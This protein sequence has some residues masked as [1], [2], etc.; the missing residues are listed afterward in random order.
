MK[1]QK[2]LEN[3]IYFLMIIILIFPFFKGISD[4]HIAFIMDAI[5]L[6]GLIYKIIKNGFIRY[7]V[8]FK[9]IAIVAFSLSYLI[10]SIYAVDKTD[11][12][13][14]FFKFATIP[15]FLFLVMQY[16]LT[17]SEKN[18]LLNTVSYS[19]A[20][21]VILGLV[22]FAFGYTKMFHNNRFS[23]FFAY[24]NSFAMWLLMGI[25]ITACKDKLKWYDFVILNV[26][27]IGIILT[28]SRAIIILSIAVYI[29]IILFNKTIRK[30]LI[31]NAGIMVVVGAITYFILTKFGIFSRIVT[32]TSSEG[33]L[34]LLYYKDALRMIK[35]NIF[36]YG[37]F[38]WWNM[39]PSFQTGVYYARY[40]HNSFLQ[41]VFDVGII[42][43]LLIVYIFVSGFFDKKSTLTEKILMFIVLGHSLIDFDIEFMAITMILFLTLNFDKQKTVSHTKVIK[44]STG[45]FLAFYMYFGAVTFAQ[46]IGKYDI[47]NKIYPYWSNTLEAELGSIKDFDEKVVR[48]RKVMKLNKYY[49]QPYY[50][51][52]EYYQRK[53]NYKKA[54]EYEK[55]V[56]AIRKYDK[57][58]YLKYINF[59]LEAIQVSILQ[60][61]NESIKF[62]SKEIVEVKDKINNVIE[63]SDELA[64]EIEHKPD[65]ELDEEILDMIEKLKKQNDF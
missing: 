64:F 37:Y 65:L 60:K 51:I 29:A 28:N 56:L 46:N 30:D 38:A 61:D 45:V 31:K 47:A 5:L 59:L 63:E 26:L 53:N 43:A 58:M 62:Y 2:A 57:A 22:F 7:T 15:V 16:N 11:A 18:K 17:R 42:P 54:H 19:G 23:G 21:M 3:N 39:Q 49:R 33:L 1:K 24:A 35:E 8:D 32:G 25:I 41:V 4:F 40:I 55:E 13:L 48:A 27:M 20:I 10:V 34:R 12:L 9:F 50:V 14:G 6:I 36:G 52:S 44:I